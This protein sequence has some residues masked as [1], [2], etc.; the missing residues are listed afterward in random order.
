MINK[1]ESWKKMWRSDNAEWAVSLV[2]WIWKKGYERGKCKRLI[3]M[4]ST[5]TKCGEMHRNDGR[6]RGFVG[7]SFVHGLAIVTFW[8][9]CLWV[10]LEVYLVENDFF[11]IVLQRQYNDAKTAWWLANKKSWWRCHLV[12]MPSCKDGD[13]IIVFLIVKL[14]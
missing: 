8:Y 2:W 12:K 13:W 11:L 9:A 10:P 14:W 4:W 3:L 7:W 1:P 5:E 6:W